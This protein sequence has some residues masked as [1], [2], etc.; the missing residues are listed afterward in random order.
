MSA[1]ELAAPAV[2][3]CLGIDPQRTRLG[4]ALVL[5][6]PPHAPLWADT[7]RIDEPDGGWRHEQV[8]DALAHVDLAWLL[9]ALAGEVA[10]VGIEQ[11]PMVRHV[12]RFREVCETVGIVQSECHRRWRWA[13]QVPLAVGAWKRAVLGSGAA[14]K[15]DVGAWAVGRAGDC[16]WSE[17]RTAALAVDQDACDALAIATAAAG[18][19]LVERVA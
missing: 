16:G 4:L 17:E 6:E 11:V 7:L 5:L 15:R 9:I 8:A 3:V 2:P 18:V 13:P 1:P 14:G 12:D 10:R 19:E